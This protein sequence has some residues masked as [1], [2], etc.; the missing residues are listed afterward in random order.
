VNDGARIGITTKGDQSWVA[1]ANCRGLRT[2]LFYPE[3]GDDSS[4]PKAVC[5]GCAVREECL[6]FAMDNGERHGVWGGLSERQ[7][8]RLR[9]GWA[10]RKTTAA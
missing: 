8:R 7:R 5:V 4:E 3:R 6:T 10:K 1:K 2:N 9:A